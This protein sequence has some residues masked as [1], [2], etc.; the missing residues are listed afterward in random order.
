MSGFWAFKQLCD[1]LGFPTSAKKDQPP[2]TGMVLLGAD[3][4]LHQTHIQ[5]QIR[6]DRKERLKEHILLALNSNSMTPAG[7]SKL[8]W[9]LGFLLPPAGRQTGARD[10][11]PPHTGIEEVTSRTNYGATWCGG[12]QR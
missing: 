4:S 7:A 12:I 3:V 6:D 5:A 8:R 2:S 9:E 1:L 10:D 11:G